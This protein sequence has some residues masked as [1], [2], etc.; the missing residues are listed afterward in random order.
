M[1]TESAPPTEPAAHTESAPP[2]HAPS[3]A[4]ATGTADGAAG[5]GEPAAAPPA[6]TV[7]GP[8]QI[9][10]IAFEPSALRRA[11]ISVLALISAWLIALWVFD[12]V[13]RFLFLLLLSWLFAM[14]MEPA[15]AWLARRGMRR[16]WATGVV[17]GAVLAV[18]VLLGVIFGNVFFSQ[19]SELVQ[20]APGVVAE[21]TSWANRTFHLRL[22][23][24]S[25]ATSLR[26]TPG[27]VGTVASDLAGGVLGLVTSLL[28]TLLDALT[29]VVFAFYLAA[30]GPR[31]RRTIGSWLSP[32]HQDVFVTVWDIAVAKTGGYVVSKVELA[33]LSAVFHATFFSAVDV[34]YWLP[35]GV[36]VGMLAQFVPVLGTYIGI[37][38][39]VLFVVFSSP[40]T[41]LWVLLFAAVY[42]QVETYVF[43]PRISRRTM[44][45][46]SGIALGAVFVGSAL[47]GVI[48]ALIGIPLAAAAVA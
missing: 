26:L 42:Q 37:V 36:L 31:V 14:A 12:A 3:T 47:W 32:A 16:G 40:L 34:P 20:A 45:V 43:T 24:N 4:P 28:A 5:R 44:D 23:A 39:P 18:S 22:D 8:Q 1:P 25:V 29:F 2:A 6:V 7:V 35:L 46:N 19:T 27:Q 17:G 38:V 48:G 33:T 41:A 13:S 9:R 11:T 30:D 15:V 10:F 21:V